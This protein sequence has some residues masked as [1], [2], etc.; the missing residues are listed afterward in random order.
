MALKCCGE[1]RVLHPAEATA[2]C[3]V[4]GDAI[5]HQP[6]SVDRETAN[7]AT[8]VRART[9]YIYK[10]LGHFRV[11][12]DRLQ[13]LDNVPP[14]VVEAVHA[15]LASLPVA[16]PS[17]ARVR[18]ALREVGHPEHFNSV[19]ALRWR[20]YCVAPFRLTQ[21]QR[22]DVES[23]F[24]DVEQAFATVRGAR[25]NM[26]SYAYVLK[27]M[28]LLLGVECR[29]DDLKDMKHEGKVAEADALWEAICV[30]LGF[31]FEPTPK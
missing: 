18:S 29:L 27:K 26:L 4:C 7:A 10:R 28:L 17:A 19:P 22:C 20:L 30:E 31:P 21:A 24:Y 15:H 12:L 2:V 1:W 9:K 3:T 8:S 23:M 6:E 14:H 25:R 5:P 11:W 16:V 13:G